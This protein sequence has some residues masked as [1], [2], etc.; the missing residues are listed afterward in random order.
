LFLPNV[1]LKYF[2]FT[3]KIKKNGELL[4]CASELHFI[5]DSACPSSESDILSSEQHW[6]EIM[7]SFS[8]G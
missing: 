7:A 1:I 2:V 4:L 8:S 6:T 3:G 5:S